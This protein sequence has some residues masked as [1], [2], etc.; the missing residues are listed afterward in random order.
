MQSLPGSSATTSSTATCEPRMTRG[1]S[2]LTSTPTRPVQST[3]AAV[4]GVS[5]GT[6]EGGRQGGGTAP[7]FARALVGPVRHSRRLRVGVSVEQHILRVHSAG[8]CD[9]ATLL[10]TPAHVRLQHRDGPG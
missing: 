4:S 2:Q 8:V 9:N 7:G 6:G 10:L 1:F 3:R 5:S